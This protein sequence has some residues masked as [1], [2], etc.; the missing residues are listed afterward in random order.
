MFAPGPK[1]TGIRKEVSMT[2]AFLKTKNHCR[3]MNDIN[4]LG[5]FFAQMFL[6]D[7]EKITKKRT[8]WI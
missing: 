3:S 8:R 4:K 1:Y 6:L 7:D 5:V 2:Y